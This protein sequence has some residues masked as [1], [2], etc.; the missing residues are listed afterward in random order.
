[1]IVAGG[2]GNGK[3]TTLAALVEDLVKRGAPAGS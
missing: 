2:P 3:T 1:M